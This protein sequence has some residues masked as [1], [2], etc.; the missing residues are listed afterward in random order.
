MKILNLHKN[1]DFDVILVNLPSYSSQ[2]PSLALISLASFLIQKKQHVLVKDYSFEF[3]K[4]NFN[5][6]KISNKWNFEIP[7]YFLFGLSNWLN[8]SEDLFEDERIPINLI[9]SLCPV[10]YNLYKQVFIELRSQKSLIKDI[11]DNYIREISGIKSKILGFSVNVGNAAASLY[12]A[13]QV[14][15]DNPDKFIVFGGP[16]VSKTYRSRF[17]L[18]SPNVDAIIHSPQGE[19]PLYQILKS[20]GNLKKIKGLGFKRNGDLFFTE[21]APIIDLNVLPI[22]DY[23]IL[24]TRIKFDVINILFSRGCYSN[25]SFCNENVMHGGL[26]YK[27]PKKIIEELKY[28]VETG[29]NKF[30]TVDSSFNS[31]TELLKKILKKIKENQL[32]INWGGNAECYKMSKKLLKASIESGLTHCYYG[33]ESGSEK[34]LKAMKKPINLLNTLNLIKEGE[35]LGIKQYIYL[36]VGFPGEMEEDFLK[37]KKFLKNSLPFIE[38]SIISVFTLLNGSQMSDHPILKPIKLPPDVLNAFT[39]DTMDTITHE[40]RKKRFLA[41]KSIKK[42]G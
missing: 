20:K 6:I 10:S 18:A 35:K 19:I 3:F 14:K 17:Y 21:K 5:E 15:K 16:E 33:I 11:L 22:P 8:F 32:R 28:Y 39:Y 9:R 38:G 36:I 24:D 2:T 34:I 42:N 13:K 7:S 25:C 41:L 37:T 23:N 40:V 4:K 1:I 30:E 12:V 26:Y 31:D 29:F 27:S